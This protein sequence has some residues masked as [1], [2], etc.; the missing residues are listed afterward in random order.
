MKSLFILFQ[1]LVPQ[2]LLSRLTGIFAN[3]TRPWLKNSLIRKFVRRYGVNMAEAIHGDP[4]DYA[5][6]N[7]FFTR[8]LKPGARQITVEANTIASPADG[9][10]SALGEI[11]ADRLLQ[12][13]GKTFSLAALLGNDTEMAD[14]FSEGSFVT[15]YLAP[16][17]YHRVHMPLAG[18]LLKMLYIPGKLFSVNQTTSESIDDLFARNERAVCL[19]ET[20]AGPMAVILVGAMI[21]AGIETVWSGQ[22]APARHGFSETDYRNEQPA[23]QL[24]KGEEMGRFKLGSTVILLFGPGAT[25]WQEALA[26]NTAVMMGESLGTIN[27]P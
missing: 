20:D 19:F 8:A 10:I 21:V 5:S 4:E 2:H 14:V 23:I 24:G 3:S 15:I 13:K 22:V 25:Q 18:K 9:H 16:R 7:D 12:A 11:K 6:F 27:L 1:H 17:D 26:E